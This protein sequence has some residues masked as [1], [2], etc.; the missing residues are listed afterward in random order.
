[1]PGR[2]FGHVGVYFGAWVHV[3]ARR[4]TLW[5]PSVHSGTR[6][7]AKEQTAP[8]HAFGQVGG[9][10]VAR[11]GVHVGSWWQFWCPGASLSRQ[12]ADILA[13]RHIFR[14]AGRYYFPPKIPVF[15]QKSPIFWFLIAKLRRHFVQITFEIF[16]YI[17]KKKQYLY[18]F[19]VVI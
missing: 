14:H 18:V 3:Q 19:L 2:T 1:M 5:R 7:G 11:A 13:P 12:P 9:H 8:R 4:Q 16:Y 17:Y 15:F 6:A 10:F